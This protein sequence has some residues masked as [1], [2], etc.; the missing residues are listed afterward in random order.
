MTSSYQQLQLDGA[1]CSVRHRAPPTNTKA[2]RVGSFHPFVTMQ[3]TCNVGS[4][5]TQF[6]PTG[7]S[8][9]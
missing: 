6:P 8:D 9:D 3:V 7:A 5:I 1:P 2:T 4:A